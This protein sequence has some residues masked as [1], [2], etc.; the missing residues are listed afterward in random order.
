MQADQPLSEALARAGEL[1]IYWKLQLVNHLI[2]DIQPAAQLQL[3]GGR[4]SVL[5][6]LKPSTFSQRDSSL[7][8]HVNITARKGW[9]YITPSE[10]SPGSRAS[11]GSLSHRNGNAVSLG[12]LQSGLG[13]S[14]GSVADGGVIPVKWNQSQSREEDRVKSNGRGWCGGNGLC[15]RS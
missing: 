12:S 11:Y 5:P 14:D 4:T 3:A 10:P 6:G 2:K 15:A 13:Q 1:T 8:M 7:P 9:S